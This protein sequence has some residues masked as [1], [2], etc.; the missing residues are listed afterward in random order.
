MTDPT[1]ATATPPDNASMAED[2]IDIF[3]SPA[4]VFARRAKASPMVPLIVVCIL[5]TVIFFMTKNVLST[6]WDAQMQKQMALQMKANPQLTQEMLDKSK[7]ITNVIINIGGVVGPPILLLVMSLVTWVI[8]RFIMGGTLSFG[9]T[10]LITAYSWLPRIVEGILS[11]VQG[12]ALDVSKMTSLF[13]L[14]EGAA[15]FV[16]P[17]SMTNGLYTLLSQ[18]DL[19]SIWCT[20][21]VIIGLTHAGKLDKSKA[22]ITGVVVFVLAMVPALFQVAMGK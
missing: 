16:D 11:V 22:T 3:V 5:S 10:V 19:F 7:P 21:L 1:A 4:K 17:D 13:Q 9:T 20:V 2:F 15:R 12:L 8:A 6:V 14:Q 18:V